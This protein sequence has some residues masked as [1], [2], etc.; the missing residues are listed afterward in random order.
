MDRRKV[1]PQGCILRG[2]AADA[3]SDAPSRL[4]VFETHERPPIGSLCDGDVR[5]RKIELEE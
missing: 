1:H 5:Q 4:Q 2:S 3:D